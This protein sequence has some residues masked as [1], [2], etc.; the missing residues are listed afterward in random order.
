MKCRVFRVRNGACGFLKRRGAV[1]AYFWHGF[2]IKLPIFA[3]KRQFYVVECA[4]QP[5]WHEVRL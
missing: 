5:F 2:G 1:L 3:K 4:G